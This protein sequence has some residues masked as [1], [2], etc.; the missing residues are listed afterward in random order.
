MK[1]LVGYTG[2]ATNELLSERI[3]KWQLGLADIDDDD[4][5]DSMRKSPTA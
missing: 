5:F 4:E 1:F 2:K 3:K